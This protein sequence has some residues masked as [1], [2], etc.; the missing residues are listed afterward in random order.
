MNCLLD[1]MYYS[2]NDLECF[3]EVA[4][5][6]DSHTFI[7]D[8]QFDN[9]RMMSFD[10]RSPKYLQMHFLD[11]QYEVTSGGSIVF[12]QK[13]R[14]DT[15]SLNREETSVIA[16][17]CKKK[18]SIIAIPNEKG[19]KQKYYFIGDTFY[20][21]LAA[22]QSSIGGKFL[23]TP[24]FVRD[25]ALCQELSSSELKCHALIR[26]E[27]KLLKVFAMFR[28]KE[29][30]FPL[31][32]FGKMIKGI[33]N[34]NVIDWSIT[35]QKTDLRFEITDFCKSELIKA[36]QEQCGVKLR[37]QILLRT[38]DTGYYTTSAYAIWKHEEAKNDQFFIQEAWDVTE[39]TDAKELFAVIQAAQLSFYDKFCSCCNDES[40]NKSLSKAFGLVKTVGKKSAQKITNALKE[41]DRR[42]GIIYLLKDANELL[43]EYQKTQYET[44]LQ[45]FVA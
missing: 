2:G 4:A 16:E 36:R 34:C 3:M 11:G 40:N 24:G 32:Y 37:P 38:S 44:I 43:S 31:A 29:S 42:N 27:G 35:Q 20:K 15:N 10:T 45:N 26:N 1:N 17:L 5:A 30:R 23:K 14:I 19:D 12:G 22:C 13:I 39:E 7:Q 18:E 6:I 25:M 28:N 33:N 9:L 21:T 41:F 8:F